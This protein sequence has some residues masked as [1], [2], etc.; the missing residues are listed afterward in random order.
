MCVHRDLGFNALTGSLPDSWAKGGSFA[1]LETLTL[2]SNALGG[3]LS[4]AWGT[5]GAFP[6]LITLYANLNKL[7]GSLFEVETGALTQLQYL[8]LAD[9]R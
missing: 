8:A 7:V 2:T 4:Q 3:S 6:E 9:N 1:A 5:L